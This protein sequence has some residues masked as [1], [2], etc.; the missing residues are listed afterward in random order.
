VRT[1]FGKTIAGYSHYK[2][3]A[4][5]DDWVRDEGRQAFLLSF[6]YGEKYVPQSGKKLI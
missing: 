4:V 2:W 5:H 6:D 3:N 1:Q